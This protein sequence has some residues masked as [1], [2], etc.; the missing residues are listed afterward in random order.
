M[1]TALVT[2]ATSG[3]GREFCRQL[4][5]QGHDLVLVARD[6]ERLSSTARY[7]EKKEGISAEI[8]PADLSA[9]EGVAA[10]CQR[11]GS[12]DVLVN[13]AGFGLGSPFLRDALKKEEDALNVM[14]RAVMATCHAAGNHMVSQGHGVIINISSVAALTGMGTYSAHKAWVQAFTEG[15]AEELRGSGV[16]A[17]AV[18]PGLV[19]TEFHARMGNEMSGIPDFVWSRPSEVVAQSL[20]AAFKGQVLVTPTP[21]YRVVAGVARIAPRSLVRVITRSIPHT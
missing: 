9:D 3:I 21:I 11:A 17:T 8:L 7:L 6:R 10:V 16:T 20:R 15:L 14:V 18:L 5:R 1:A 12:V 13:N 19:H 4:A 2:G